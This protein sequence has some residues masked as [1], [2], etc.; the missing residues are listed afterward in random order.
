[1]KPTTTEPISLAESKRLVELEA[2]IDQAQD[3][4]LEVSKAAA[5]IRD[6][7][8]YR[9]NH[10]TFAEYCSKRFTWAKSYSYYMATCG[11]VVK[12]LEAE[13]ST[14]VE[15]LNERQVREL[16][17]A[18]PEQRVS[19]FQ[20]VEK[21]GQVT[22]KAIKAEIQKRQPQSAMAEKQHSVTAE[23]PTLA[24]EPAEESFS[25]S[26]QA[27]LDSTPQNADS[28]PIAELRAIAEDWEIDSVMGEP[29]YGVLIDRIHGVIRKMRGLMAKEME[30]A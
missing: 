3:T 9:N 12:S 19:V 17:K 18:A 16:A 28:E 23:K 1:M 6:R 14:M 27:R 25:K 5:E 13:N 30:A 7:K 15:K 22:A 20:E 10:K 29:D 2:V 4:F 21:S 11:E 24:P 8:L 26:E